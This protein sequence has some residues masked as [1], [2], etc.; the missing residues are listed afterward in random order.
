MS[1]M[2]FLLTT[3][4]TQSKAVEL[5]PYWNEG[6]SGVPNYTSTSNSHTEKSTLTKE[7]EA[8]LYKSY[9]HCLEQSKDLNIPLRHFLLER[10]NDATVDHMLRKF[11]RQS[12]SNSNNR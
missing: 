12:S 5:N 11:G 9:K 2:G 10:W 4:Q 1:T 8:W 6:G 3:L 7:N